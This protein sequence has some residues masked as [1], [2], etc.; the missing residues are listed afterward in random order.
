[1][2]RHK[3]PPQPASLTA[4][5]AHRAP[6]PVQSAAEQSPALSAE[7]EGLVIGITGGTGCG[8]TTL[9]NVIRERGGLVFDCDAIYHER[10]KTDKKLLSDI[11]SRFPGTVKDGILQRKLLGQIVFSDCSALED[12][13]AITHGAVRQEVGRRLAA[14]KPRLAAI[15][16]IALFES[17]LSSFCQITV[18]VTAPLEDR[19]LR[20]MQRDGISE[21]YARNRI[22]AQHQE[23]WFR[24]RCDCILENNGTAVQ[25]YD[26]CIA[27]LAEHAIIKV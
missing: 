16:A 18:A 19:V 22:A 20:L 17:G 1:M 2:D 6:R 8:K 11:E 27:F 15:D 4:P 5:F 24:A 14:A 23:D 9:L 7:E 3:T 12:L 10:L 13:N 26:K 25:F 21:A